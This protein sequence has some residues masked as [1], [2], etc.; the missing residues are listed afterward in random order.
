MTVHP[1]LKYMLAEVRILAVLSWILAE[2][3]SDEAHISPAFIFH[4]HVQ[5]V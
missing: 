2:L 5:P 3:I 1:P 4:T